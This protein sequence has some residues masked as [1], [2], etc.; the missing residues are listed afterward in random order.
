MG[1]A[2]RA[3]RQKLRCRHFALSSSTEHTPRSKTKA[4]GID[5]N[6]CTAASARAQVRELVGVD[7]LRLAPRHRG[8]GGRG[9]E[10]RC[11]PRSRLSP[12]S[13]VPVENQIRTC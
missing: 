3:D 13:P 12:A 11:F 6:N 7:R 1:L 5:D 9:Y 2:W 8:R 10:K 4:R